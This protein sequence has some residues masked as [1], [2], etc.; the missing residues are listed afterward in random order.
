[1]CVCVW[2]ERED[3]GASGKARV[4]QGYARLQSPQFTRYLSALVTK[5]RLAALMHALCHL[6][7]SIILK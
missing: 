2:S 1:V 7:T 4:G 5:G 6:Q 3:T